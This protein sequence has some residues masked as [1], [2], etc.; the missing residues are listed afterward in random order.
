V[1]TIRNDQ[2]IWISRVKL[3][4]VELLTSLDGDDIAGLHLRVRLTSK[5]GIHSGAVKMYGL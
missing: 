1:S 5:S 4:F 3:D 2:A